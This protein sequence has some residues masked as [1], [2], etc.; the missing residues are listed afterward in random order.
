VTTAHANWRR[1]KPKKKQ[2]ARHDYEGTC[3]KCRGTF[4]AIDL[5]LKQ[6]PFGRGDQWL[7][8]AC[9]SPVKDTT[10][11]TATSNRAFQA[12]YLTALA[13]LAAQR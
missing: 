3:Q 11:D 1:C 2:A 6:M 4:A 9:V 5:T 12:A 8:A 7:C 10:T 13:A